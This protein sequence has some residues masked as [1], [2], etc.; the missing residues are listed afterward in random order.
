MFGNIPT[1]MRQYP[2]WIVWR[3]EYRVGENGLI[4]FDRK[5]T[6]VPYQPW[7]GG[8]KAASI[9]P[10]E[11]G[12]YDQA[13]IAPFAPVGSGPFDPN[14]SVEE[15]GF[16]GIGFMFHEDNPYTGIDLDDTHGD[17]EA[18]NRQLKIFSEF[19]S[20]SELSP[21]G[22]GLHIIVKGKVPCGRR[23]AF[24]E[25]YSRERFFTMTGNIRHNMPIADRQDL[26]NVLF[27][28]MGGPTANEIQVSEK[29]QTED[30]EMI[31]ARA[32]NAAN[33]D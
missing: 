21:S 23:R 16:S 26:L 22:T 30:D 19:N 1:E 17:T 29:P 5:P 20:Y 4:D 10:E 33:G 14:L 28:E 3:L 7:P 25:L 32:M 27:N 11:W 24:V 8:K 31:V 6:K 2:H 15:T 12:T 18:F 13:M 9:R